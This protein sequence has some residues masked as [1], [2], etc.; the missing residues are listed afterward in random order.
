MFVSLGF[1]QIGLVAYRLLYQ[2]FSNGGFNKVATEILHSDRNK[3]PE[4]KAINSIRT[5]AMDAVQ[6]ANSGH[7]GTPVALA[8]LAYTLWQKFL[9]F[10]PANPIWPNRD[11]AF[12]NCCFVQS[13]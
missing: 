5:L 2:V 6:K 3:T 8:P 1:S 11:Q 9:N 4:Q 7:P 10:D 13:S 12:E